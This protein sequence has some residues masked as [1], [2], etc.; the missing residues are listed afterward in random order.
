MTIEKD[1]L[2]WDF[3]A[4]LEDRVID[5][6][7]QLTLDEKIELMPQYQI[8]IERLGIQAYKHGTEAA[9]GMAWL[10][11]ATSYPQPIGLACTWDS[12]LL[13]RIGSA[14]GDEARGFYKQN[15]NF[16][17]LT[18]W[19]PTVDLERDPRWG[20][21]EEAY[22][23]DPVLAGKLA[24]A[25]T[26]GI[27][28]DHPFYLK[29]V[30]TL[31]HFIGNN[32][33][34]GRGDTSVSLDP[35]NLREYYLKVFEITFKEGGAQSMM[36]AYNAVNGVPAN[37]SELVI[38]IVKGEWGMNGFVVSDAFDV[39]GTMRDHHY[40]ET[41]KEAVARSIR[42]GGIDSITDDAAVVTEA[43]HEALKD[44]LLT[45]ND[46]D[47]ALRNT[48]RVRFRLGE[49]DPPERNPYATIDESAIL[50]PEHAKL[51][52]EASQKA[53]VLLKNDEKTLPL[54][55]DKLSKVAVIGPLADVVYQDWYSGSLPYAVTPLQGIR[56][57]LAA[58][59]KDAVTSYAAGTDRMRIKAISR[60]RYVRLS[61]DSKSPLA[62]RAERPEEGDIFEISDW[63]WG[64]HTL[65]ALR[66]S[67][68]VT[69]DDKNLQAS[70]HRI[71]E[72]FT[73]E[74]FQIRPVDQD[75]SLVTF[76]TWNGTPVTVDDE[77]GIL[78][79]GDGQEVEMS[80]DINVGG[81]A[82]VGSSVV[83]TQ[84]DTFEIE[85]VSSGLDAAVASARGADAAIVFVGNH[86][87]I[88]GKETMDRPDIT[89][90]E[91]QEKL[92]LAVIEKN[93]NTII[94]V[95][96]SYPFA[97]NALQ[98]K[99]KAIIYT[100]HA[101]QELGRAVA[102]VLFGDVNPAGRLNMTWYKSVDQLPP[103]MDYDIIRG[104]RTYQYF[105]GEPLY[106][107]GHGLSYS[108]FRYEAL[109]LLPNRAEAGTDTAVQ[110]SCRVTNI[111]D[112]EG[113]EVV[114]LYVRADASRVKRPRLQL[115]DFKR[116]ALAAGESAE[117]TFQLQLESLAIWDVTR[118]RFC[119]ESGTYTV[120]LGASSVDLRLDG[121]LT[122]EGETIPPRDLTKVTRAANY[123][124]YQGIHL[125]ECIEGGSAAAV[126]G[127]RGW[128]A[129]HDAEL[130]A[131]IF[132]VELRAAATED[133][134]V[135]FR[136]DGLD[137]PIA[138]KCKIPAGGERDWRS[139]TCGLTGVSGKRD[140][141]VI[142]DGPVSLSWFR[143]LADKA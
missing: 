36:T 67:L 12:E 27:Q 41:L 110:V 6:I 119:L 107:F 122:V 32:N 23:E 43:I 13:K 115:A 5:L 44:G 88:N 126:Y 38:D 34:A 130:G 96:G 42:E 79:V 48:F 86:P 80:N 140:V 83:G 76:S 29:A 26:Q 70:A 141:Y 30:A 25:L 8:A 50:H 102:A 57:R 99:A 101:G 58:E 49:F 3:N 78:L 21:T 14:I 37:L 24:A 124:A 35:R 59:G 71:W 111:S 94:V 104:C 56:E 18:L 143:M 135:E 89:L 1:D 125:G 136:L 64:S 103:F 19:A 73:K 98:E 105:E 106:P 138:G 137:G 17:G 68:F 69:T 53:V 52:R 142:L 10:G 120:M 112:C 84:A 123:D 31:K 129:F 113:E 46:L 11:E 92:A 75:S 134:E 4:P 9:H 90:A 65:I 116:I 7:A 82:E 33:E 114:Q 100:S 139:L 91:S 77:T 45:E 133:A 47:T 60:G 132:A 20:R 109:Q 121:S 131:G 127:N 61:E 85:C 22:G 81:A 63:G 95:V 62:A 118:D 97:L 93:P 54:Q 55:A 2:Y 74:V 15:P 39:T 108:D 87:L 117:V 72:W 40:V 128:L 51:A 28:G 66:N 16:N